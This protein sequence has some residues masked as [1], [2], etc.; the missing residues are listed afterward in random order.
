M[1]PFPRPK[2]KFRLRNVEG[3]LAYLGSLSGTGEI[4]WKIPTGQPIFPPT[5]IIWNRLAFQTGLATQRG[6]SQYV[7]VVKPQSG[8]AVRWPYRGFAMTSVILL[9]I[10]FWRHRVPAKYH[11]EYLNTSVLT[12]LSRVMRH[13]VRCEI[14]RAEELLPVQ[15]ISVLVSDMWLFLLLRLNSLLKT[16]A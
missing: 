6:V 15:E 10:Y 3:G 7:Q 8:G 5:T 12:A 1:V 16:C 9:M 14:C 2:R 13:L 4:R 11:R